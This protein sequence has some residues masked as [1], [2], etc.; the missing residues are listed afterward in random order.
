[1]DR[2]DLEIKYKSILEGAISLHK[3]ILLA[4]KSFASVGPFHWGSLLIFLLALSTFTEKSA[5]LPQ[6]YFSF[7]PFHLPPHNVPSEFFYRFSPARAPPETKNKTAFLPVMMD[8]FSKVIF[9][10]SEIFVSSLRPQTN[11]YK[12]ITYITL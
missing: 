9:L 5:R 11:I 10:L 4:K 8:D 6:Y 2:K 7:F 3:D 1:M 12:S